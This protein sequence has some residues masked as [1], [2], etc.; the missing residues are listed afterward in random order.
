MKINNTPTQ[1]KTWIDSRHYYARRQQLR[2]NLASSTE[3]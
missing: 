1:C 3:L 2:I